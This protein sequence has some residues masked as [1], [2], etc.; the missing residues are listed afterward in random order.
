MANARSSLPLLWTGTVLVVLLAAGVS[1]TAQTVSSKSKS[2]AVIRSGI[3]PGWGQHYLGAAQ[4]A[5]RLAITEVGLWLGHL[6][7]R[8]GTQWYR[9]DY[10]A[11]AA[12]HGGLDGAA[13]SKP[14]IYYYYLGQYDSIVDYNADM[15][16]R[17]RSADIYIVG[18]ENDWYWD[19]AADRARYRD[20]R[21]TS[22]TL[23]KAASFTLG[24][25]VLNRVIAGLHVLYLSRDHPQATVLMAPLPSGGVLTWR[26]DL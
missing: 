22:L 8:Q 20:L 7:S 14:D 21:R 23:A 16:R 18:A 15:L 3:M 24:G 9:Q 17:R 10:Q 4:P 12:L 13:G 1:L 5:R 6:F 25:L 11:Y 19:D 26:W 2:S